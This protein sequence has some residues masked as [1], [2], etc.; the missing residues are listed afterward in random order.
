MHSVSP[1][2]SELPHTCFIARRVVHGREEGGLA[3]TAPARW[4]LRAAAT[5]ASQDAFQQDELIES[6][7]S[8]LYTEKVLRRSRCEDQVT[9]PPH[10]GWVIYASQQAGAISAEPW[11]PFKGFYAGASGGRVG[12]V[13]HWPPTFVRS[14]LREVHAR[15]AR[16]NSF[17]GV[18]G[19]ASWLELF[20][21]DCVSTKAHGQTQS[22]ARDFGNGN[23]S[24]QVT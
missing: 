16:K 22:F 17:V 3:T 6:V 1:S 19:R 15:S 20:D 13:Q 5:A 21:A 23:Q 12:Q 18:D 11:A 10:N 9:F 2:P 8:P 7:M 4:G 14:P 24:Y